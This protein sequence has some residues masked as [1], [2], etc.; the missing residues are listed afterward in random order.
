MVIL[1]VVFGTLVVREQIRARTYESTVASVT[2]L[3]SVVIDRILTLTDITDGLN[4]AHRAELNADVVMLKRRGSVSAVAIW[5]LT[6]GRVVYSDVEPPQRG[7]PPPEVMQKAREGKPFVAPEGEGGP[8]STVTVYY[9]Y[10]A[11]GDGIVDALAEVVLPR[12][13]VDQSI[14]VST[15]LLYAGGA[16]VLVLAISGILLV[17]RRQISQEYAASHDA[18]TGLGNRALMRLSAPPILAA[19][20]TEEPAIILLIDLDDFKAVNDTFGHYAGDQLLM[21]VAS[22]IE[23][24]SAPTGI[25]IR[26]GGDEFA[27][28]FPPSGGADIAGDVASRIRDAIRQPLWITGFAVE[29]DAS[30][31]VAR[32]PV[33]GRDL[34]SLLRRADVAMYGAKRSGGGVVDRSEL[35]GIMPMAPTASTWSQFAEALEGGQLEMYYQPEQA[36]DGTVRS[37][38]GQPCWHHPER[39]TID[40]SALIPPITHTSF[41]LR[42]TDWVLRRAAEQCLRLRAEGLIVPISVSARSRSLY[43]KSLVE[44]MTGILE[45]YSLPRSALEVDVAEAFLVAEPARTIQA[46]R[47]LHEAGINV[48]LDNV[49]AEFGAVSAVAT[50]PIHRTKIDGR[51]T[52]NTADPAMTEAI[53]GLVRVAHRRNA[54]VVALGVDAP[55]QWRQL[56]D[57]G[58]DAGVGEAI[59]PPLTASAMLT[60]LSNNANAVVPHRQ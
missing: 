45:Q 13:E 47:A 54:E 5:S 3:N 51:L 39:G 46:M 18:L 8:P 58:C 15:R 53:V 38:D 14:A 28:L 10:D 40:L 25:A 7:T 59:C 9:P 21:S 44:L 48:N 42:L 17:R 37:I 43:S 29:V 60:W 31:G 32:A 20:T 50:A 35:P 24:E 2:V 34:D 4:P 36:A 52:G 16:L 57:I 11:N 19:G 30:I 26:L 6:D 12:T 41:M 23:R 1:T 49:G 27:V 22:I 33:D 55:D 56:V